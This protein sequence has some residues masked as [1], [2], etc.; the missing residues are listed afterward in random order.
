[1]DSSPVPIRPV[2]RRRR[3]GRLKP[4]AHPAPMPGRPLSACLLAAAAAAGTLALGGCGPGHTGAE[5]RATASAR[6]PGSP[7]RSL[8][9]AARGFSTLPAPVEDPAVVLA[10]DR[11]VVAGGRSPDGTSTAAVSQ[12]PATGGTARRLPSL[13]EPLHDGAAAIVGA[14]AMLF[15]GGVSQGGDAIVGLEP[16]PPRVAGR[17][18]RRVSDESAVT[19]GGAAYVLGGWDGTVASPTVYRLDPGRPARAVGRLARGVRYAAVAALGDRILVAGGE[20]ATGS[21]TADVWSF[22]P[23]S[24]RTA[25]VTRLT[26]PIDHAAAVTVGGRLYVLGGLRDGRPTD[27]VESWAPGERRPRRAGHLPEA[28]SHFAAVAVPTGVVAV[29]GRTASGATAAVRLLRARASST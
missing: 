29:G 2:E 5:R 27:A 26:R 4:D 3:L 8:V 24:G 23:R 28:L 22:D 13:P 7:P 12:V 16:G 9:P 14:R 25:L 1:M 6:P 19:I 15:G 21:P 18:P 20:T 10:G 17:L 11:I